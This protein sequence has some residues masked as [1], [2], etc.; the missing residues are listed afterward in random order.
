MGTFVPPLDAKRNVKVCDFDRATKVGEE[1]AVP[2]EPFGRL[3]NKC[4]GPEAGSYKKAGART[5][6][7]ATGAVCHTLL[8]G[9]EAYETDSWGTEHSVILGNEFQRREF[10]PLSCSAEDSTTRQ[11]WN[12]RFDS[13]A[14][15]SKEVA[16]TNNARFKADGKSQKWL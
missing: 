6:S 8:K 12:G 15:L 13:I 7:F 3:L 5:K 9:H 11:C 1:I 4:E 16:G 14:G 10:S 2:T